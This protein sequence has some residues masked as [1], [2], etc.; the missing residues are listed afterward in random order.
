MLVHHFTGNTH[1]ISMD[2]NSKLL[3]TTSLRISTIFID[4]PYINH[5]LSIDYPYINITR[6]FR[7]VTLL[8]LFWAQHRGT[9]DAEVGAGRFWIAGRVHR[10]RRPRS[11]VGISTV[12]NEKW[13]FID[14]Y[15]Y[16]MIFYRYWLSLIYHDLPWFTMM[17][18]Y[19]I[20]IFTL[21]YLLK[22]VSLL[23]PKKSLNLRALVN[24]S[25]TR[26]EV[27]LW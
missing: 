25:G 20:A 17:V 19:N 3:V 12:C 14:I 26:W 15:R 6:G 5:R 24:V 22:V 7:R 21:I 9:F 18:L 4:H 16:L 23:Q 11:P 1:A 2:I 13:W 10:G 8:L 27:V